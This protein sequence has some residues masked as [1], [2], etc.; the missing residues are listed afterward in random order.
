MW[1]APNRCLSKYEDIWGKRPS[2]CIIW[3]SQGLFGPSGRGRKRQKKSWNLRAGFRQNGFFADFY[4]WAAGFF[5][6]FSRRIFSPHFCGK[7]CPEKSSRKIPGKIL[8][9]LYD[10][11]PPTHFCRLAG[12]RNQVSGLV[13]GR[14][15]LFF[16][17]YSWAAR[18]FLREVSTPPKRCDTPPLYWISHRHTRAIPH[19]AT[20]CAIIVRYPIKTSTTE[21]CDT[22]ARSIARYG[23]YRCWAS[24]V[25]EVFRGCQNGSFGKRSFCWGDTRHFRHFRRFPGSEEQN[26][27]FLWAECDIRIFANFRQNHLFSA[28]DKTTV[29]QNDRFDNPDFFSS[30][31]FSDGES[32][33]K[34]PPKNYCTTKIPGTVM[35]FANFL[36]PKGRALGTS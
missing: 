30:S 26:P 36:G 25:P 24:K 35:H 15:D 3:I 32:A 1:S 28:G 11:N 14:A 10:K 22:I 34:N 16:Y 31:S 9:N 33:Q 8:Q 12:A 17:F 6:G 2:S 13:F 23:K 19:F 18:Y 21:F 4:F 29:F 20:Y 7:K 5:R 27:L